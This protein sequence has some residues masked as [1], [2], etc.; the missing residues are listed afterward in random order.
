MKIIRCVLHRYHII[1]KLLEMPSTCIK[2]HLFP[3]DLVFFDATKKPAPPTPS[4]SPVA[5]WSIKIGQ[6]RHQLLR[7]TSQVEASPTTSSY[8]MMYH[9]QKHQKK[10]KVGV[11]FRD[12]FSYFSC[13]LYVPLNT[14]R[15]IFNKPPCFF[16]V[17]GHPTHPPPPPRTLYSSSTSSKV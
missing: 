9:A 4:W 7:K 11:C 14:P 15:S 13:V 1:L 10:T 16:F 6:G 3:E 8:T 12:L 5:T 2:I 17:G